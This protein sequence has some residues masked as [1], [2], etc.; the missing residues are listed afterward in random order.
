MQDLYIY[1]P[2]RLH[3]VVLKQLT[4]G[5]ISLFTLPYQ[6]K[7]KTKLYGLSPQANYTDRATTACRRS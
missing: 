2:I 3:G 1:S 4:T 7:T 5:T 6:T